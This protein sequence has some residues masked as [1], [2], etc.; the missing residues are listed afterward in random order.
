MF[1]LACDTMPTITPL[2]TSTGRK[3]EKERE[4]FEKIQNGNSIMNGKPLGL[5]GI[6]KHVSEQRRFLLL[7]IFDA[8]MSFEVFASCDTL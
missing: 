8:L 5:N 2:L 6:Q 4:F 3:Q 1:R 7:L